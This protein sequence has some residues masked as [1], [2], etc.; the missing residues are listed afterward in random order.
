MIVYLGMIKIKIQKL[1]GSDISNDIAKDVAKKMTRDYKN[2]IC[3]IHPEKT[4]YIILVVKKS[5]IKLKKG[6]FCC[7]EFKNKIKIR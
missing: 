5:G 4:S 6:S 2:I 7:P 3:D 1:S